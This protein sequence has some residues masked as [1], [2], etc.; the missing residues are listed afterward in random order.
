MQIGRDILKPGDVVTLAGNPS[1]HSTTE[2]FALHALLPGG[3]E[4][5]F[6]PRGEPRW[7]SKRIG[8]NKYW[9]EPDTSDFAGGKS[10]FRVW[11]TVVS[12]PAS[13]PLFPE[14]FDPSFDISSYPL[15]QAARESLAAFNPL[16]DAPTLNCVPK[17]MPTIMEQ[18]YPMEFVRRQGSIDLRIEEYDTLRTIHLD[19]TSAARQS[20]SRLGHSIGQFERDTLVVTTTQ[21][22][23]PHFDTVGIPLSE[24][25]EVTEWFTLSDD[26]KTLNY[27]LRVT[28]PATFTE[29]VEREKYWLAVP[30]IEV[31]PYSCTL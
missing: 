5:V 27:R 15:T 20:P 13:F 22:N 24:D 9:V 14:G 2:L 31:Q 6:D 26:G 17:G 8:S 25:V 18:P 16:T 12:D 19:D 7:G 3:E 1:K 21:I 28:D 23:W 10:L 29:P 4:V 11:S 30:G